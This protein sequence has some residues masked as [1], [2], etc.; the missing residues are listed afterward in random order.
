MNDAPNSDSS[1]PI[2]ENPASL[3]LRRNVPSPAPM[4]MCRPPDLNFLTNYNLRVHRLSQFLVFVHDANNH[5]YVQYCKSVQYLTEPVW[6]F[7]IEFCM[8]DT[9]RYLVHI[10]CDNRAFRKRDKQIVAHDSSL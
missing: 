5:R 2:T 9:Y 10:G 8:I 6:D 4:S 7:E 3:V 1:I